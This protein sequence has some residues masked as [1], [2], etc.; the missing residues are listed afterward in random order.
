MYYRE[1][2]LVDFTLESFFNPHLALGASRLDVIIT[3]TAHDA[4]GSP[5]QSAVQ[6]KAVAYLVDTSGSMDSGNKL[7]MA[8][9][10]LRQAV[11]LLDDDCLFSIITFDSQ[12]HVVVPMMAA[13]Q[14]NKS[15]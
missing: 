11:D 5:G 9:V 14:A 12:A 8:K 3:A 4:A 7:P 6:K 13:T 2:R 10:A 15:A 1:G